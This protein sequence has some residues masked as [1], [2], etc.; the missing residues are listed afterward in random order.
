[1]NFTNL[2]FLEITKKYEFF[3]QTFTQQKIHWFLDIKTQNTH[4]TI[5]TTTK[6]STKI[7]SVRIISF[8]TNSIDIKKP[9]TAGE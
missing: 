2:N 6:V 4:K 1:M 3:T 9:A 8:T 7:L 5:K